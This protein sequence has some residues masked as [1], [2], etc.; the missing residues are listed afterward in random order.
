MRK[1]CNIVKNKL[2]FLIRNMEKNSSTFVA[3][4]KRDFVRKSELSFSKTMK[5]ILG[6]GSQ[7]LS[8]ELMEFYDYD[9]KMVSVSATNISRQIPLN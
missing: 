2:N 1:Y 7:T 8:K 5:F 6:M 4:P 3:D 9:P